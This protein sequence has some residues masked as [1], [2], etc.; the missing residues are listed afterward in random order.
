VT[1]ITEVKVD[2]DVLTADEYRLDG[3]QWLTRM[4]DADGD[5]QSWP[6]GQRMDRVATEDQTFQVSYLFGQNPPEPGILAAGQLAC[7]IYKS[8]PGNEGVGD[9]NCAIPKNA[10]RVT[11]TGITIELGILH[12]DKVQGRW[13]TGMKLVDL[14]LN[15]YNPNALRRRP[16]IWS[17]DA[18]RMAREVGTALGS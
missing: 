8:C 15:A 1:E 5:A 17:P 7:E 9:G 6:A 4:A 12:F 14:F 18:P 2:G 16:L 10:T 13:D 3:W 11:R